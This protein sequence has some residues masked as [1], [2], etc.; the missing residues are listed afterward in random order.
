M[1]AGAAALGL[2]LCSFSLTSGAETQPEPLVTPKPLVTRPVSDNSLAILKG[3]KHPLAQPQYDR[4]PAAESIPAER[5]FLILKRGQTREAAFHAFLESVQDRT[6]PDYHHFLSPEEVGQRYGIIDSDLAAINGWLESKGLAVRKINKARTMI[7]FSGNVGQLQRT[8]HTPIH[9]YV[10]NGEQH[11]A[12]A[13]DPAIPS[14]LASVIAGVSSLNNF[15]VLRPQHTLLGRTRYDRR[16]HQATSVSPDFTYPVGA[17]GVELLV[18]PADAATI[19]NINPVY[20]LKDTQGRELTGQSVTIGVVGNAELRLSDVNTYRSFFGLPRNP[21]NVIVDGNDPGFSNTY[22][23]SG[24]VEATL[25]T[26][27]AG[28]IAPQATINFY[29]AAD[30]TFQQGVNLAIARAL[31]DNVVNVLSVSFGLCEAYADN[32]FILAAW[33]QASAQG[34]TVTVSTGDSGSAGCD[35]PSVQ[36]SATHG[37]QVNG[38]ASTPYNIAVGG[39]DFDQ[40]A[41]NV[42]T[43]WG[44][45]NGH[46]GGS[47]LSYIPELPWN[48][49]TQN[50]TSVANNSPVKDQ[51]GNTSIVAG[52]G[53]SS[54]C[55]NA[56][57]AADG[58]F[59]CNPDGQGPG[60]GYPKPSWQVGTGVL[61]DGARDLP[62]I[63][64]FAGN[65]F[66]AS[67]WAMCMGGDCTIAPN[68]DMTLTSVSAIGG[69][70][71]SAPAFAGILAL[72]VQEYGPQG[73]ANY[74]LYPLAAQHPSAFHDVTRG[75]NS[76]YCSANS[77]QCAANEFLSGENAGRGYDLATGVGSVDALQ[78]VSN[79]GSI[80]FHP[81]TITLTV[82]GSTSPLSIAHGTPVNLNAAVSS[83]GGSPSGNV[84][85]LTSSSS[86]GSDAQVVV[87]L[88]NTNAA[89]DGYTDFPGGSYTVFANYGGDGVFAASRSTGVALTVS[90]ENSVLKVVA[91]TFD[92]GTGQGTPANGQHIAIGTY[93]SLYARPVA[94][95]QAT[96]T[97]PTA[98]ATGSVTF[99][100]LHNG[101]IGDNVFDAY[102]TPGINRSGI[103]EQ[104]THFF[105]AGT[106]AITAS[107]PGDSSFHGSTANALS[108]TIDPGPTVTSLTADPATIPPN[109]VAYLTATITTHYGG[110]VDVM[111]DLVPTPS[112]TITFRLGSTVLQTASI[113]QLNS[114]PGVMTFSNLLTV[115]ATALQYGDNTLVASYSGD[116]NFVASTSSPLV[117]TV[118]DPPPPPPG[119]GLASYGFLTV[120]GVGQSATDSWLVNGTNGFAGAVSLACTVTGPAGAQHMPTCAFSPASVTITS[121]QAVPTSLTIQTTGPAQAASGRN[122]AIRPGAWLTGGGAS[123]ACVLLLGVPGRRQ[124]WHKA[125]GVLLLILAGGLLAAGVTGCGGGGSQQQ[126]VPTDAGTTLGLY[127]VTVTATSGPVVATDYAN[128]WVN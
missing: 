15:G 96:E 125:S 75:D 81:T 67:A 19:Y 35:D 33:E 113:A 118:K 100:D 24:E 8:F 57:V 26:E 27:I 127:T 102:G 114:Q 88:S 40:N 4:G 22:H 108:F 106:H 7:E 121:D 71:A 105:E 109:G 70:S 1:L 65:G 38:L 117:V 107:Y 93:V 28:G 99:T 123:L 91:E 41:A 20:A 95:S 11:Y 54:N 58:S 34:I 61:S 50:S 29:T 21:P 2:T 9:S 69:T 68:T 18:A 97:D 45:T 36:T 10:V 62:D 101:T 12:N 48:D 85:F 46:T 112:G 59:V 78:L 25:D 98:L 84:A 111:R 49:S 56:T 44:E 73:Q 37:L 92:L 103:A 32:G 126:G 53:G 31:D 110:P 39:T 23:S 128:F 94:A 104:T 14:A 47:A 76:V 5:L 16:T 66:H 6:S 116:A 87:P 124:V 80:T 86:A 17:N 64:L 79:W 119:L 30:T 63:S 52:G 90:P 77:P 13:D 115:P 122:P 72:V 82:D 89:V 51:N 83:S 120:P 42:A 55:I 60:L 43:Y 3:Y 74:T